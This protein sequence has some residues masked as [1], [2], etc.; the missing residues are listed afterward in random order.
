MHNFLGEKKISGAKNLQIFFIARF[1]FRAL[2]INQWFFLADVCPQEPLYRSKLD[3]QWNMA[4]RWHWLHRSFFAP[5]KKPWWYFM[6][7]GL[8]HR[9]W[10]SQISAKGEACSCWGAKICKPPIFLGGENKPA[11]GLLEFLGCEFLMICGLSLLLLLEAWVGVKQHLKKL[12]CP[13]CLHQGMWRP[14]SFDFILS[15]PAPSTVMGVNG[16]LSSRYPGRFQFCLASF[17]SHSFECEFDLDKFYTL[18]N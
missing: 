18:E 11:Q 6:P 2:S 7:R 13:Q 12:A 16:G 4:S 15:K 10:R 3:L 1:W 9:N 17:S 5:W 8:D 14:T